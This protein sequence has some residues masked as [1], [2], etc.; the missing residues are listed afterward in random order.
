M[1]IAKPITATIKH[2]NK[3]A[4]LIPAALLKKDREFTAPEFH[5]EL[6]VLYPKAKRQET[7]V[8]LWVYVKMGFFERTGKKKGNAFIYKPL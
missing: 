1:I 3:P 6:I 2:G 4:K 8:M 7:A 5:R